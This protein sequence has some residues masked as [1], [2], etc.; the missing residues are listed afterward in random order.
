[1]RRIARPLMVLF[2]FAV[3]LL[4]A[5][6]CQGSAASS[7]NRPAR[8][9][10]AQLVS[11]PLAPD[12]I[13]RKTPAV[14]TVNLET[15]EV[16]RRLADGVDYQF[17]TFNG[18]VPGPMIRVRQGDTVEL[19]LANSDESRAAH[20]IDLNSVTG[21][22]GGAVYTQ[23]SP[24][25]EK[26]FSFK[27]LNPG[28]YVYHCATSLIPQHISNGMYG[29]ILVEPEGGLPKVDKEFYVMQGDLYTNEGRD[30]QGLH[31]FSLQK[32]VDENADYVVFNG[33]VGS[34]VG[35]KALTANVG[36]RVRIYFGVG[37]PNITSSFH[38]IGEIY[39]EV[40]MEGASEGTKNVQTTLVPA[41]G[42]AWVDFKVEVPGTY[43][44]VD[45]SLGR[46]LKGAAGQLVV[47]GDQA[48]HIF[49]PIGQD[50]SDA[51]A[52]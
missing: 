14:V 9:E 29:L 48:P 33:E 13:S 1:M 4:V 10:T 8:T 49:A 39:D 25:K 24:G 11:P 35:D 3:I 36:D 38:V 42:A 7:P 51:A 40:H 17:W 47:H 37:G 46:L 26:S 16:T 22:G 18:T 32:M 52:H 45:H 19:T 5:L 20:S 44:L 2:V 34:L 23:V 50:V 43:T 30:A 21:P 6:V 15:T 31:T 28:L 27:A 41:G 12:P